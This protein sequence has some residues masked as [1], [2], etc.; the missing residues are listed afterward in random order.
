MMPA[1]SLGCGTRFVVVH[2]L[3]NESRMRSSGHQWVWNEMRANLSMFAFTN[4]YCCYA[5]V[6]VQF[7]F[8]KISPK[9]STKSPISSEAPSLKKV[10]SGT[11]RCHR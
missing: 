6:A 7:P 8:P 1:A 4:T 11:T 9:S 5:I 10:P 2:F 3:T